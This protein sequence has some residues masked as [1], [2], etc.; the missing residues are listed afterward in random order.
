MPSRW[1]YFSK[2][3]TLY[4]NRKCPA[5]CPLIS[6][7]GI[8]FTDKAFHQRLVDA[9]L[10][11]HTLHSMNSPDGRITI[12]FTFRDLD[13]P[14]FCSAKWMTEGIV[15]DPE[16]ALSVKLLNYGFSRLGQRAGFDH[17]LTPYCL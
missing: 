6:F 7:L 10:N 11:A 14:I 5:M 4:K 3:I 12:D 2:T 13:V 9:G 1:Q 15:V 16:K 8:A 17:P